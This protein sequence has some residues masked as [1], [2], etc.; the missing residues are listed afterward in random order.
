MIK[1]EKGCTEFKGT[2]EKIL[3]EYL[4]ITRGIVEIF[5]RRLGDKSAARMATFSLVMRFIA[6]IE[7]DD[8]LKRTIDMSEFAKQFGGDDNGKV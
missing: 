4:A 5:E 7:K 6:D 2:G 1:A 3:A 8:P